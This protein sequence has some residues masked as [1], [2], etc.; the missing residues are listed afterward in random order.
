MS[1]SSHKL[2][3][4]AEI[5]RKAVDGDDRAFTKLYDTYVDGIFR[6][7][8]TRTSDRVT[9]ED[10]TSEVFK[11]A[12]LNLDDYQHRGHP[13]SSWLFQIARN[14]VIDHYRTQKE[15]APLEAAADEPGP[16]RVESQAVEGAEMDRIL[17]AMQKLTELQQQVI[18]L[19][20]IEGYPTHEVAEIMN[21]NQGAIRALQM[22]GLRSLRRHLENADE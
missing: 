2:P 9:A 10:L 1:S 12:W 6:F 5:V 15:K 18:T 19:K 17:E 3:N 13:F 20:I 4:E 11:D 16:V 8:L 14:T 7:I 21:K 22:R